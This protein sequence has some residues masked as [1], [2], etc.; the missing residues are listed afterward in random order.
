MSRRLSLA[1]LLC[2]LLTVSAGAATVD[3]VRDKWGVPH[4]FVPTSIGNTVT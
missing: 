4:V 2:T 3:V 1:L